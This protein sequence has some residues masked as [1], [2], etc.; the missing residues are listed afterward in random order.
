MKKLLFALLSV[1]FAASLCFAQE[2][3]D[4]SASASQ[5]T[6]AYQPTYQV[7]SKFFSGKVNS[8]SAGNSDEGTKLQITVVDDSGQNLVLVIG[9]DALVTDKDGNMLDPADIKDGGK[10]TVTY[11]TDADG[12]NKAQSIKEAE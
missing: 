8:V 4:S 9:P 3:S 1:L 2:S 11:T 7:E 6:P 10:V 12:T 5:S